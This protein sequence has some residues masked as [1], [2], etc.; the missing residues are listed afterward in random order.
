MIKKEAAMSLFVRH[1]GFIDG[2]IKTE[3]SRKKVLTNRKRFDNI[4]KRSTVRH[5]MRATKNLS[6]KKFEKT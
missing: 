3:K 6:R 1:G 2:N 5:R 4:S